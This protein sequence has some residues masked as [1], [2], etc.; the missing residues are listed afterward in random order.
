MLKRY[1]VHL[2][3]KGS[4]ILN[5]LHETGPCCSNKIRSSATY[6]SDLVS[7]LIN[8]CRL[9]ILNTSE[10]T[11]KF[12]WIM[13]ISSLALFNWHLWHC[14]I[15]SQCSIRCADT[16]E[17]LPYQPVNTVKVSFMDKILHTNTSPLY[18]ANKPFSRVGWH[19]TAC[20][21]SVRVC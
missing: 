5:K 2:D 20:V 4:L 6:S 19:G 13:A 9:T 1:K 8:V 14:L 16:V 3:I 21:Y 10:I 11:S 15:L 17:L 18:L 12:W 7:H